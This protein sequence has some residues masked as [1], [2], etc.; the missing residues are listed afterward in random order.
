MSSQFLVKGN[1]TREEI[2]K[3]SVYITH[4]VSNRFSISSL[5][6]NDK[7]FTDFVKPLCWNI[8][9][10]VARVNSSDL[11]VAGWG[12]SPYN[13]EPPYPV[14]RVARIQFKHDQECENYDIQREP[15]NIAT[16]LE[17]GYEEQLEVLDY[18]EL[19]FMLDVKV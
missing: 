16:C 6:D 9:E 13:F 18:G 1:L 15:D 19:G 12:V 7:L 10:K 11:V 3:K 2:D 14:K 5:N 8:I 17:D 4:G